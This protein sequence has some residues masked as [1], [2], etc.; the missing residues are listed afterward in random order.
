MRPPINREAGDV[1]VKVKVFGG[2]HPREMLAHLRF[3]VCEGS[4]EH[5][6]ARFFILLCSGFTQLYAIRTTDHLNDAGI[7][8]RLGVLVATQADG[9][10]HK[11]V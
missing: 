7:V 9:E 11:K 5:A 3:I 6:I 10:I 2:Q 4:A 1:A 8:R